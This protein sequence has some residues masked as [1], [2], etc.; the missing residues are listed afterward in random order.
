MPRL[1][2]S[3]LLAAGV[4]LVLH[5]EPAA[6]EWRDAKGNTFKAE[7][8]EA[9]GPLA[10]FRTGAISSRF[11][12]MSALS[13]ADCVRFYQATSSR[14][15]RASRWS[16]AK[17]RATGE[18]IGRLLRT[19]SGQL[20]PLD[21]AGVPE[22]ELL[23]L[24]F[25][26][27]K[28]EGL[29]HLLDNAMPF[30]Q[31]VERVYPGRVAT[32]LVSTW[33]GAFNPQW[34]PRSRP[35]LMADPGKQADMK[36]LARFVPGAGFAAILM[37][38]EG[39]PLI[40]GP[41]NDD[42][43]LMQFVDRASSIL[44]ELNPDNP[45]TWRDRVH[46]LRAVRPVQF[47]TTAAPP[48]LVTHPLRADALRARGVKRIVAQLEINADGQVTEV[49]WKEGADLPPAL[50]TPL[51]QALARSDV[52]LPAIRDGQACSGSLDY[53][54]T[55]PAPMEKQAAADAAWV[56]GEARI[57]VPFASWLVLKPIRLSEQAFSV[58]L[59]AGEDGVTRMSAMKIGDPSKISTRSQLNAFNSDWFS[60]TGAKAV[61]PKE[62]DIQEV[63]GTPLKWKK[64][65]AQDG[66]VDFLGSA[67][68]NSHDYCVGYAWTEVEV[69]A[70]T[71]AWLGIGSD[72]GLKIWLNG[73]LVADQWT[74][75]TSKLDDVIVPLRLRAGKNQFLIKIQNVKGRWSFTGRLRVRGK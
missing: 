73:E 39:V 18:F 20:K 65:K 50:A 2:W 21:L 34:L 58:V 62:G 75:R 33:E 37:T 48:L 26:S 15:P 27:R 11:V 28:T 52:F 12:P 64:M 46:Y 16:E 36:T 57:D 13:A 47:A 17:G 72:D 45:R 8:V 54:F 51:A 19:E 60:E 74:E 43:E 7:A 9:M 63:D 29:Y 68:Y 31:R 49:K 40:G 69:T 32:I 38:R 14:P 70:E 53:D 24:F 1:F 22:P 4:S 71:D 41:V 30:A 10:L 61:S 25:G 35:W 56:N 59:G 42:F 44:W 23:L 67:D 3:F 66:L 6:N 55:L 5:A